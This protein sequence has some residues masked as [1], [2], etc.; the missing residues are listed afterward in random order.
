MLSDAA[1]RSASH[2]KLTPKQASSIMDSG[3]GAFTWRISNG[4]LLAGTSISL[5][6]SFMTLRGNKCD[7]GGAARSSLG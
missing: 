4:F 7:D 1:K 5:L 3:M 2:K 6:S